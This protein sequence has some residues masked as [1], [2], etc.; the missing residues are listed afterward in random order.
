[1]SEREIIHVSIAAIILALVISMSHFFASD[2]AYFGT[3]ILFAII[4]LIVNI[5]GKKAAANALDADVEHTTWTWYQFGFKPSAH[6]KKPLAIGYI[7]P[8]ILSVVSLGNIKFMSLLTYETS[9]LKKRVAKRF[10]MYSFAEITDFHNSLVGAG[11]IIATLILAFIGYWIPFSG[12]E[13]LSRMAIFYAFWNML[14]ISKLDGAQIFFG[15]RVVW[16]LLA[17]ITLVFTGYAVLLV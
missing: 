8:L 13:D 17:L 1:M 16:T 14:P 7:L 15:S 5:A 3:A 12:F 9:A 2:F 10:G 4:I 11:G 6:F